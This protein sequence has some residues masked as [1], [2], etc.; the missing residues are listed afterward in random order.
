MG[1]GHKQSWPRQQHV[2]QPPSLRMAGFNNDIS[3]LQ[4]FMYPHLDPLRLAIIEPGR[5]REFSIMGVFEIP[6]R[7]R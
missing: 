6:L 5:R 2:Q 1:V 7:V 3:A 4:P